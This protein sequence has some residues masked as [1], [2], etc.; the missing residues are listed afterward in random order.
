MAN[1]D[2]IIIDLDNIPAMRAL[3][4]TA[5]KY[6]EIMTA[7]NADGEKVLAAIKTDHI[8]M[9]TTQENGWIRRNILWH[10]GSTEEL[11]SK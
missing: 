10:D 3:M 4:A 1:A 5:E 6:P 9:D 11:Y 7:Q 8:I 2:E